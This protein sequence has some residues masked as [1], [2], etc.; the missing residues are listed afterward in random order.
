MTYL[1]TFPTARAQRAGMLCGLLLAVTGGV[2]LAQKNSSAEPR[3]A[4]AESPAKDD[5]PPPG[6]CKPIGLTVSGEVVFP[7]ECRDFIER[8]KA[9]SPPMTTP[10]MPPESRPAAAEAN[11]ESKTEAKTEAKPVAPEAKPATV[12]VKPATADAKPATAEEKPTGSTEKPAAV[13]EKPTVEAKPPPA[14]SPA[15]AETKPAAAETKPAAAETKPAPAEEAPAGKQSAEATADEG[16]PAVK[17][18]D[19]A[20]SRKRAENKP[21]E[22][23]AGPPGC[24]RFRSYNAASGTYRDFDGRT[25]SCR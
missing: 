18:E 13:E 9:M 7:L 2:A 20:P 16:K 19:S 1:F 5:Q 12:E 8:H 15:A 24:T 10:P 14:E 23:S 22:R 11:P 17:P 25:R 3:T 21:R 6:A 4:P